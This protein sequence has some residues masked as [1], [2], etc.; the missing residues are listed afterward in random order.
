[1]INRGKKPHGFTFFGHDIRSLKPGTRTH[2][3]AALLRR[4]TF[5]YASPT[6]SGKHFKGV[7]PVY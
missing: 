2:F 4:G 7:F 1:M 5:P 3:T 6:D